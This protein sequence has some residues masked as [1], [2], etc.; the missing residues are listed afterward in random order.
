MGKEG[1]EQEGGEGNLWVCF[2][3]WEAAGGKLPTASRRQWRRRWW[4]AV[5]RQGLGINQDGKLRWEVGSRFR[6][7]D[8]AEDGWSSIH[9]GELASGGCNGI[10]GAPWARASKA[11]LR[12]RVWLRRHMG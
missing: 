9:G 8:R 3:W 1:E 11:W 12:G 10:G 2:M 5:L 7:L 6:G 4:P